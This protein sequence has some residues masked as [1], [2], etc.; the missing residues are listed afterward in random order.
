MLVGHQRGLAML[1]D[2][3][4]L[5]AL[6][7]H[8][9]HLCNFASRCFIFVA[10]LDICCAVARDFKLGPRARDSF[11]IFCGRLGACFFQ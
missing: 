9:A 3:C 8:A 5:V 10:M 4:C 2:I 1:S 6:V 11:A 7:G